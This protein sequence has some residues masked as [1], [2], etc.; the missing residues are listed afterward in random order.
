MQACFIPVN[1]KTPRERVKDSRSAELIT[2][3]GVKKCNVKSNTQQTDS[4]TNIG[5]NTVRTKN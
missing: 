1:R 3:E 4:L 2:N 5:Q